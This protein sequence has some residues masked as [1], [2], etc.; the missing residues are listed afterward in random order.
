MVKPLCAMDQ[1]QVN[2]T[3]N[4]YITNTKLHNFIQIDNRKKWTRALKFR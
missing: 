4:K 2:F 1:P 3:F